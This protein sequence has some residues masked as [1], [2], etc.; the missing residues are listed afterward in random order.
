[1]IRVVR[2][3]LLADRHAALQRVLVSG[4]ASEEEFPNLL[5]EALRLLRP[6][7][8]GEKQRRQQRDEAE[9]ETAP[10][11]TV[12]HDVHVVSPF[13]QASAASPSRISRR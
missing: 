11:R 9:D 1:M 10:A 6:G 12:R 5:V 3:R 8:E 13:A 7:R 4:K 2:E